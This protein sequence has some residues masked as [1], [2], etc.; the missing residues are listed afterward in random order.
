MKPIDQWTIEDYARH[1][2][3][4]I[5]SPANGWGQHCS[6]IFGQAHNIMIKSAELFGNDET[7]EAIKKELT[8]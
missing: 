8:C 3:E 2:V 7:Q 4:T 5:N 1:Y 6:D